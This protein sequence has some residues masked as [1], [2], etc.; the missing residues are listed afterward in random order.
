MI[1]ITLNSALQINHDFRLSERV[2]AFLYDRLLDFRWLTE[3][4][5]IRKFKNI[6]ADA[7]RC[8]IVGNGPSINQQKLE[9]LRKETVFVANDFYMH[10]DYQKISPTYHCLSDSNFHYSGILDKARLEKIHQNT[11][12][13][14]KFVFIGLKRIV[15][16]NNL[17]E[18]HHLY[19]LLHKS[20]RIW[21]KGKVNF[22]VEKEVLIGDTIIIDYCI[23]LAVYMGITKIYLLGCDCDYHVSE[24]E[25]GENDYRNGYF[26]DTSILSNDNRRDRKYLNKQWPSNVIISY[27]ILRRS[28]EHIGISVY[29]AGIGGKLEVFERVDYNSLFEGRAI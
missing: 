16:S 14:T 1:P 24:T 21:E 23:P 27:N 18:G 20:K 11:Q 17:F 28:L 19:Y 5:N 4:K 8:F 12:N 3:S 29:N 25:K 6:H 2:F 15:R 10:N 22:N 13:A 26:F 9:L 7:E